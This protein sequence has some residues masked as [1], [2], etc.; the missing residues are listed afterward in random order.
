MHYRFSG[1]FFFCSRS[2]LKGPSVATASTRESGVP[3]V[4]QLLCLA[5]HNVRTLCVRHSDRPEPRPTQ[6]HSLP[7]DLVTHVSAHALLPRFQSPALL[8]PESLYHSEYDSIFHSMAIH[9]L[10]TKPRNYHTT[11]IYHSL[12]CEPVSP[13]I[14]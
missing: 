2:H 1:N 5:A 6:T 9:S 4:P 14:E 12:K 13:Y 7:V 3:T 11:F 8:W 10:L